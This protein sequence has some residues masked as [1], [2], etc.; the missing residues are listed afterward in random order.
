MRSGVGNDVS[1]KKATVLLSI[2]RLVW[3]T[4]HS[5]AGNVTKN[6]TQCR[7]YQKDKSVEFFLL[8]N[9]TVLNDIHHTEAIRLKGLKFMAH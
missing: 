1:G 5:Y 8:H 4:L 9:L 3:E 7:L 2:A 6:S